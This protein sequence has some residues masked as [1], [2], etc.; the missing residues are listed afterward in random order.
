MYYRDDAVN[1]KLM[2]IYLLNILCKIVHIDKHS[3]YRD[4]GIMSVHDN[5][6]ANQ[7]ESV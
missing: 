1:S 2:G 3:I 5:K 6:K 4:D 7:E